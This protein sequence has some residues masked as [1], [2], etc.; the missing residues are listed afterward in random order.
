MREK[1]GID[2]SNVSQTGFYSESTK[3][4][5]SVVPDVNFRHFRFR[6][7]DGSFYKVKRKI[8]GYAD[9]RPYL[10]RMEPVDIYYS[11][12]CWLNPHLLGSRIDKDVL[13]NVMISCD[14]AFDIDSGEEIR[15]LEEARRQAVALNRF[16]ENK[17]IGVRYSAFS[18]S[19][20]FHVV[21]NDP[22]RGSINEERPLKREMEAIERR[23]EIVDEVKGQGIHFDEKVT[24]DT[25]RIIRLPG[26]VN[27]KTGLTCTVLS[28][29]ELE[30][31]I[32]KIV[33]H[34]AQNIS[35]TPR[36]PLEKA[37]D[38]DAFQAAKSL[39]LLGRLGVRPTPEQTPYFSTFITSNIPGTRLKIPVL[40]YSQERIDRIAETVKNVQSKYGL[41][42]LFLFSD[43]ER[44]TAFSVK[45]VTRR[46]AEKILYAAA[47]MNLNACR[48]YGCTYTRVGKSID[49]DGKTVIRE[50]ELVRVLRSDLR[51]Q[52]SRTHYEF[53]SSLGVK[54][55]MDKVELC[56]E[57]KES[58]ELIHAVIE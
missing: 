43:G 37:G 8:R 11:T 12:A 14:L 42:D 55:Q 26:T 50:P 28:R 2:P 18:G 25:R 31:D 53:L 9:L 34:A 20:G 15:T 7:A 45:A 30:S 1:D 23:K 40:E 54:P 56:G 58:L 29:E 41:G 35:V 32:Q 44:L 17:G 38:D 46:R 47:S 6:L 57:G 10:L 13:K 33:K 16:L 24:V 48:K 19:R 49:C 21:C 36:I 39:G 22:W 51:G 4:D 27:S 3:I 5:L 52:A